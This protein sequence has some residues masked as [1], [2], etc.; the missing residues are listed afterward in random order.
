MAQLAS[1]TVKVAADAREFERGIARARASTNSFVKDAQQ[2]TNVNG[3]V[4]RSFTST[5][6]ASSRAAFDL[7]KLRG[8]MTSVAQGVLQLNPGLATLG[9]TL[10]SL[11][12]TGGVVAVAIG[13]ITALGIA[14]R[15]LTRD[16]KEAEEAL[17]QAIKKANE[18][19]AKQAGPLGGNSEDLAA[20]RTQR[21]YV[22]FLLRNPDQRPRLGDYS[23][24]QKLMEM[25]ADLTSQINALEKDNASILKDQREEQARIADEARREAE[26]RQR[27]LAILQDMV[28]WSRMF[29]IPGTSGSGID[30]LTASKYGSVYRGAGRVMIETGDQYK[31][32]TPSPGRFAGF[33]TGFRSGFESFGAQFSQVNLGGSAA[34]MFLGGMVNVAKSALSQIGKSL[35][36]IGDDSARAARALRQ[37]RDDF[38]TNL[39]DFIDVRTGANSSE[40]VAMRNFLEDQFNTFIHVAGGWGAVRGLLQGTPIPDFDFDTASINEI[41]A[42]FNS[43]LEMN[44]WSEAQ[45]AEIERMAT[46]AGLSADALNDLASAVTN[47]ARGFKIE[48]YRYGASQGVVWDEERRQKARGGSSPATYALG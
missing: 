19:R 45:R 29:K 40:N 27:N 11:S 16:T 1:L 46:A 22:N 5:S 3:G 34:S 37:A 36:G 26:E 8:P 4:A 39:Q 31:G 14:W 6:A 28:R 21:D 23:T 44:V 24:A 30:S 43:L 13:G 38:N 12:A 2:L 25:R 17:D 47:A 20:L 48:P 10:L 32:M 9:S 33:G 42:F 18:L 15:L 35:L 7:A 41:Q